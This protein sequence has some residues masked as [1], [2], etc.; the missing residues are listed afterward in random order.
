MNRSNFV[1]ALGCAL[2]A[3]VVAS[4]IALGSEPA[5]N[6]AVGASVADTVN[7][8]LVQKTTAF[9]LALFRLEMLDAPRLKDLLI[10]HKLLTPHPQALGAYSYQSTGEVRVRLDDDWRQALA[11]GRP[12]IVVRVEF[13]SF[14][15]ADSSKATEAVKNRAAQAVGY[16]RTGL[17]GSNGCEPWEITAN[18]S[19]QGKCTYRLIEDRFFAQTKSGYAEPMDPARMRAVANLARSFRIETVATFRARGHDVRQLRCVGPLI[20][21]ETH[22]EVHDAPR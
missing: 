17:S 6:L 14:E 21:D 22:C 19:S 10:E 5:A 11:A 20:A 9:D 3:A 8:L 7:Q 13:G 16:V 12:F 1:V 2:A 18:G 4:G 15:E